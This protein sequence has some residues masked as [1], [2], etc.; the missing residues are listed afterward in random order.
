MKKLLVAVLSLLIN[1]TSALPTLADELVISGNGDNSQNQVSII[2]SQTTN[3]EQVNN[4]NVTNDVA[5]TVNTGDNSASSNA[6]DATITTGNIQATT[7]VENNLVN[8]SVA[9]VGCCP[10]S[11][12]I[13]VSDNGASSTNQVDLTQTSQTTALVYQDATIVNNV[14]GYAN[15][16][17]N[18]ANHNNG[19]VSIS[20]GDIVAKVLLA[21]DGINLAKVQTP[22]GNSAVVVAIWGNGAFSTNQVNYSASQQS[23]VYIT[24]QANILNLVNWYANTGLNSANGNNGDV[25]ITTGDI[26]LDIIIRN[27]KINFSDVDV[28][29]CPFGGPDDPDDPG[30]KD[31]P[32]PG[33]GDD[34]DEGDDSNDDDRDDDGNGNGGGGPGGGVLGA[35]MPATGN[36]LM[37][38]LIF[39]A[40]VVFM[41]GLHLR[42]NAGSAPPFIINTRK[43]RY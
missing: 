9:Q 19:D 12:Q 14:T 4:A 15:T 8:S 40:L 23:N 42:V 21:N 30:D 35:Q 16:G 10:D 31:L 6:G 20:T 2:S 18:S 34:K 38:G 41:I 32:P 29:C 28:D 7:S 5:S 17:L 24:N 1:L 3:V 36:N 27:Y 37:L 13:T 26:L 33:D 39:A 11:T 25:S 43:F 22:A